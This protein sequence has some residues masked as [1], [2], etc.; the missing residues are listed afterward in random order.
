MRIRE[1][2]GRLLV[3]AAALGLA[4]CGAEGEEG[5][6]G[7]TDD[8]PAVTPVGKGTGKAD[9]WDYRNDPARLAQFAGA[10]LEY[11]FAKLPK[12]GEAANKPW[13]ADY[14]ATYRDST[15]RR[16]K[17]GEL[18][19]LE[20]YDLA[21]NGWEMPADFMDLRPYDPNNC[22]AGF[23]PE[24][25]ERL[26]PAA[27]FQSEHKGNKRARDLVYRDGE[28]KD[29]VCDE[30]VREAVETWWGLCHAWAP[31]AIREPEPIHPVTVNG[32]TFYASDIKAL[33]L[34]VYDRSRS[35]ILGG[36]CNA[37]E[38]ER[39]ETGRIKADECRDTN[40][41]SFHV[42]MANFLGRHH[43]SLVED[44]TY[45]YEVWNQPVRS[46]TVEQAEEVDLKTAHALLGVEEDLDTYKYNPKAKRFVEV[47]ARVDYITESH[48]NE[49]PLVTALDRYTRTD[50]YHYLLE[51]DADG[52]IIGGEWLQ[53]RAQNDAWG[54]SEQPD[55][56]WYSTGPALDG[57]GAN[58]HVDY[59][60]VKDLL[61]R[62]RAGDAADEGDEDGRL[63]FTNDTPVA[64]PDADDG[65]AASSIKVD[66][67][68]VAAKLLVS[69]DIE[70]TYV[71]DLEIIL[72]AGEFEKVLRD[73]EGGS[74]DD[75]SALIEVPEL[76]GKAIGGEYTLTVID[77]AAID[78]GKIVRWSVIAEV[79]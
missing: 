14:W 38:V 61:E 73:R 60:V 49:G 74:A 12:A 79:E 30:K 26:G 68:R 77:H 75:I 28:D 46:F 39:D 67:D 41:G 34:T 33:L 72:T 18:S 19:P 6:G 55:F 36:R 7:T 5:A 1:H 57:W 11:E 10:E 58:P 47:F 45:D 4:A 44:R 15:N 71:G 66:D 20:K 51:L 53:G 32:V 52:K 62:S 63:T 31:A 64:I 16:W 56:L 70:H 17:S 59:E 35:M 29:P 69:L 37:K 65:G 2:L 24:Y 50:N 76:A 3:G 25:Y 8:A 22:E 42:I 23:D 21:F 78:V 13:P 27:R 43:M 48:P 40:A 9:A 54:I